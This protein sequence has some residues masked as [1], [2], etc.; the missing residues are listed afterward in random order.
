MKKVSPNIFV[1]GVEGAGLHPV[2]SMQF[3]EESSNFIKKV[4]VFS[5]S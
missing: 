3:N 5:C 1:N 2:K 4:N